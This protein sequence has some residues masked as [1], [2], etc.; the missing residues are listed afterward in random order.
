MKVAE[1]LE[2]DY[3]SDVWSAKPL[4]LL[5]RYSKKDLSKA[6]SRKPSAQ[7]VVIRNTATGDIVG[8]RTIIQ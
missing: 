4:K 6:L 7:T 2:R 8:K 1:L 3:V 5:N